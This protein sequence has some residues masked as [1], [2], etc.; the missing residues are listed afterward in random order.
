M[1]FLLTLTNLN[2]A[3]G[4]LLD[5]L[6]PLALLAARL[7]VA[8]VFWKSGWIKFTNW[9]STLDLFRDEYHVPVLPPDLAAVAGTFGELFFPALLVLGLFGR[10]G[11]LGAFAVN[12]MAVISYAHVLFQEGFEAAI[13]QHILWGTLLIG[14]AVFGPGSI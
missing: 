12:A 9:D 8:D 6:Q 3:L 1:N 11:A 13:G 4:R 2:A 7:Y 10:F 14:L 5:R